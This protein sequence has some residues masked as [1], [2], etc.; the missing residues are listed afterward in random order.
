MF[1]HRHK[2][3]WLGEGKEYY[4]DVVPMVWVIFYIIMLQTCTGACPE[5][6][7]SIF[8]DEIGANF[9]FSYKTENWIICCIR[10]LF[11][12]IIV[13]FLT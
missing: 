8:S 4:G 13:I 6:E 9:L 1:L 3:P 10:N 7:Q 2:K 5:V 11:F 12:I